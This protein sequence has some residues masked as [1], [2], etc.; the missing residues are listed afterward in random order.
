MPSEATDVP[1]YVEGKRD[2]ATDF[3]TQSPCRPTTPHAFLFVLSSAL[4]FSVPN[5]TWIPV[6]SSL[7]LSQDTILTF[8][9]T[10]FH[11][12]SV[13]T[14]IPFTWHLALIPRPHFLFLDLAITFQKKTYVFCYVSSWLIKMF[15][16]S[17]MLK[18]KRS[19][20]KYKKPK[21]NG[22]NKLMQIK[23]TKTADRIIL[24]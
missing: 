15:N 11:L 22:Q 1:S 3:R 9:L 5:L 7:P 14:V 12:K 10:F 6:S 18:A 4:F 16:M 20:E 17:W 13:H 19:W 8:S 23:Y 24:S 21:R 2:S